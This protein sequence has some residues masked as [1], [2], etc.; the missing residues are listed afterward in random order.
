MSA[1]SE[2][3]VNLAPRNGQEAPSQS[4]AEQPVAGEDSP[5]SH[6][7][8]PMVTPGDPPGSSMET[9]NPTSSPFSF[10]ELSTSAAENR[11]YQGRSSSL[12]WV[13]AYRWF[14]ANTFSPHWMPLW[15][16]HPFVGCLVAVL[17]E[18]AAVFITALL[19]HIFPG[20]SFS[21][22]LAGLVIAL[23]ALNWGAGPSLF[24]TLVGGALLDFV[25]LP[26]RFS[27]SFHS[28][29]T[30]VQVTLFLVVGLF[31]SIIASQAGRAR[32]DAE[33]LSTSLTTE[34]KRLE[35]FIETVPDVVAIYDVHGKIVRL[36]RVGRQNREPAYG[37]EALA[38]LPKTYEMST[39]T[40]EPIALENLP[41]SRA[42]HGESIFGV[43]MHYTRSDGKSRYISVSAAPLRDSSG[44]I[45]GAIAITHDISA[46][47]QSERE[48]AQ[49]AS[50][51]EAMFNS[52]T[53]GVVV[54]NTDG[55][56]QQ[57]NT[58]FY[59][60]L[61]I[62]VHPDEH[63]IT[64]EEHQ[65]VLGLIDE[66]WPQSRIMAGETLQGAHA[67][68]VMLRS[69]DGRSIELSVSGAPVCDQEGHLVGALCICRDVTERRQL[70]RRTHDALNALL[71][72]AESLVILPS[73]GLLQDQRHPATNSIARR[74]AELTCSV[75]GCQRVGLQA[76]DPETEEVHPLA[77]VGLSPEQEQQ[78]WAEQQDQK[79]SLK[80]S[81]ASDI[82]ARLRRGEVVELDMTGPGFNEQPNPYGVTTM[83][84]APMQLGEHILGLL[85]LDYGNVEHEYTSDELAL[86]G[87]VAKL[88]ALVI[89]R[90]RLL[91]EREEAHANELAL[92]ESNRQMEEFLGMVSHELRTPLTSIK[93]NT[94][95]AVRQ[96][97]NSL[98]TFER[99]L[100]LYEG[101]ERQTRRLGRLVDDL[102]DVSRSQAG[103]L[104]MQFAPYDIKTVLREAIEEQQQAWPERAIALDVPE[105]PIAPISMDAD[106]VKQVITNYLTNAFKYSDAQQP[107]RVSLKPGEEQIRVSVQDEG[108]GLSSEEHEHIWE[109]FY[110]VPEVAVRHTDHSSNA[111]L[112]LGLHISKA[113]IEQHHGQVGVL[114]HPGE[115][116]SF[117]FT[118]PLPRSEDTTG[119]MEIDDAD[120]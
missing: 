108:P 59:Q 87:A 73:D 92:R 24:A 39:V 26:P 4:E 13:R 88:T 119:V 115:G 63:A 120:M 33:T 32:R 95:L 103:L 67:A 90:E 44:N 49:R 84:I 80:D 14:L 72:M 56:I 66:R 118:L 7:P 35:A 28:A 47:H 9:D 116:S 105:G 25:I 10:E 54:F 6:L 99:I 36:N 34:R 17:L 85:L 43:E 89:E 29:D 45:E 114:S 97:K 16:R 18:V 104:E 82:V 111:G 106:R 41:I 3:E 40:G 69:L 94:Q 96:L 70:E 20:V 52:I 60:L 75:M 15:L 71:N 113:I 65:T 42:L 61:G 5:S 31:I 23:V 100:G 101:A 79:N 57:A 58:A 12:P 46:L 55:D 107:V 78:W 64:P 76:V 117:W 62:D 98:Q 30:L 48:A 91:R 74:L 50:E 112:G 53:D 38:D 86:A 21:G 93:G 2:N 81:P 83:L 68:D 27:W 109:R 37:Q 51:L 11:A 22:L 19:G 8:A 77:V 110:R 102:L 1:R